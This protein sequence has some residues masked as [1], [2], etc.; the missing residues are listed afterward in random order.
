MLG[1]DQVAVQRSNA[2]RYDDG[3]R[4]A[5]QQ[6]GAE[7]RD[8]TQFFLKRFTQFRW[9]R[10]DKKLTPNR[11]PKGSLTSDMETTSGMLPAR[12][13]PNSITSTNSNSISVSSISNE[14]WMCV[15]VSV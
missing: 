10:I 5:D 2:L 12:Y 1:A 15:C 3:E 14:V 6:A 9:I 11:G 7:N 8:D 13:E 4:S